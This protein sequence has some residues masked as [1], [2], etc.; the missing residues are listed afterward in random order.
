VNGADAPADLVITG[1]DVKTMDPDRPTASAIA[2]RG[3]TIAAV[4]D[5]AAVRPFV[6][7]KT[8]VI[9]LAGETVTP[10]LV[11]G[12]CHLY[13]LGVS[14]D[15]INVRGATSPEAVAMTVAAAQ[16]E[17]AGEWLT[18]RGWDQNLWPSKSF[19][20]HA[21]LDAIARPVMLKRID[22]HAAWLNREAL[23]RAGITRATPDPPGG[24]IVR[25]A[26]GEP[27][28][29]LVDNAMDIVDLVIPPPTAEVR[30]ARIARAIDVAISHGITA[31]HEMGIED[32]TADVYREMVR[33]GG[34]RLPL[35]VYAF[36][37]GDPA[38]A[39]ALRT[40]APDRGDAWFAMRAVK[41]FADGAMGSRGARLL[42]DY[43]D[44]PGN[45]GLW[46]TAPDELARAVDAAVAGG[47]QVGVH[48]IGDAG[49]RAVLD[50]FAAALAAHPG[51]HRL[52]IEHVQQ[53]DPADIS[54]LVELGVV[55]SM[56]PTHATSDMPWAE[57]RVGGDRI[58]TAYAWRTLLDAG[59]TIVNGSDFPVEEV[60]PLHG[61]YAAV[62]RQD[63]DG[64]PVGGWYPAER[65]TLDEAIRGFTTTP[66]WAAFAEAERGQIRV[67]AAADLTIFDRAL[68]AGPE[69]LATG[70]RATIVGGAVVFEKP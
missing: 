60:P 24:K 23:K 18:G 17:I 47:W 21:A 62:T 63:R 16:A 36:L 41:F 9:A 33:A 54:R 67:G 10:G 66:S 64:K 7:P 40:R 44:D 42:A 32:A 2:V 48:A 46:R 4:G 8:R 1:A 3:G 37:Q 70:V 35:R 61:I 57:A 51:D 20:T 14:L 56:Q 39:E 52:R 58:R 31:V 5:D 11:D 59:A 45:R 65:M 27:T 49:N 15:S 22:G 12:H 68:V 29:V 53:I 30:R 34:G 43:A 26:A 6:G 38:K 55:A 19:P 28:G 13:N 50:A 69:L 25:D